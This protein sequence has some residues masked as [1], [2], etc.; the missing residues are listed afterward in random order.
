MYKIVI[1]CHFRMC[2][3]I[4]IVADLGFQMGVGGGA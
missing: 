3:N 2:S 4:I 1:P